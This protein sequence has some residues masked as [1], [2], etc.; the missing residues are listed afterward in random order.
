VQPADADPNLARLVV[1]AAIR[2]AVGFEA[3]PL[4][5]MEQR[6]ADMGE[7]QRLA[8]RARPQ[9]VGI[10]RHQR[11]ACVRV[12]Q[13]QACQGQMFQQRRLTLLEPVEQPAHGT[14]RAAIDRKLGLVFRIPAIAEDP[15]AGGYDPDGIAVTVEFDHAPA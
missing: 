11:R 3:A 1:L 9:F 5:E 14:G 13:Q 12:G 15:R 4:I 10:E 6:P 2:L 7:R 8:Q